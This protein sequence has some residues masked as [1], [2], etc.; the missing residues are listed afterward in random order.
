[1]RSHAMIV[2][3]LRKLMR[4]MQIPAADSKPLGLPFHSSP[5][6]GD[7]DFQFNSSA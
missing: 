6:I 1:M 7:C 4:R 5:Q 2:V 3:V